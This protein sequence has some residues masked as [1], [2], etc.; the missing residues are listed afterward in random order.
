MGTNFFGGE[1][2]TKEL[3]NKI[4]KKQPRTQCRSGMPVARQNLQPKTPIPKHFLQ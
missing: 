3:K 4:F 2:S 1:G